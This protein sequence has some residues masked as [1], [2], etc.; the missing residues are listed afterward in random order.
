MKKLLFVCTGNTC[1]SPMAEAIWNAMAVPHGFP[2]AKSAGVY[3]VPGDP[4]TAN[5]VAAAAEYGGDLANHQA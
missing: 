3:A 5:A 1:R 2:A 4:A